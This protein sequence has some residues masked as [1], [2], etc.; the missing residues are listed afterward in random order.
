MRVLFDL[1]HPAH[2]HLFKHVIGSLRAAGHEVEII[3]RQKDC[4]PQLLEESGLPHHLI[5]RRREG[6]LVLGW[7]SVQA[8]ALA[9]R[10]SRAGGAFD[11]MAGVS[12]SIG[13][14]ARWT[15][16]TALLFE[17]DDAKVVPVFAKLGYPIAHYVITPRCLAFE[18]HGRKHLTYP[19]YHELAYLHPRRFQPDPAVLGVLGVRPGQRYA[20]VRLV[21]LKAHHDLGEKGLSSAQARALVERLARHGPVFISA[22]KAVEPAL[23]RYLLPTPADRI[24]DVLAFAGLLVGDSQTMAAE[25]AVLGVP[26]LRCNTFKGRISYLE[27]L[28]HRYGLTAAFL[29]GEFE[30]LAAK[31]QEWLALPDLRERWREKR[32]RMLAECV[33]VTAWILELF[34]RLAGRGRR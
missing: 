11:L 21:A 25:A 34:G 5:R 27:E 20:L 30:G 29:P 8:A 7:E 33:D 10:L 13:P 15:G 2:F 23:E 3:A 18:D 1:L 22:E 9:V 16:A 32:R 12:I 24:F 28:E 31:A 26:S 4:L 14:A 19:G 17:D 6:L